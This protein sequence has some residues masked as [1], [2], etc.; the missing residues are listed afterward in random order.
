VRSAAPAGPQAGSAEAVAAPIAGG[1]STAPTRIWGQFPSRVA[2]FCLVELQRLRHDRTELMTRAVQPALWLLIYGETFN[3]LHAIPTGH[4]PYLAFLTPGIVAQ[5]GMFVAIF[6]GIQ[7]IWE[8]DAGVL[9]KL[10]VTPTP[11]SALILGKSFA[12]GIRA[13]AQV[14]VVLVLAAILGVGLTRNPLGILGAFVVVM[15]G[16]AFFSCLSMTVAGVVLKRDRLMGVGQMITMP[17]FFASS[18]LYPISV[19]PRWLQILS[20]ANPLSYEVNALRG[21]L[22]DYPARLGLDFAVLIFSVV[23]GVIAASSLVA[24]LAR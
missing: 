4:V 6:Y 12:A 5:S 21:L 11:R 16:G 13:I 14:I 2:T 15:L 23:V 9:T 24:R 19:M 3:R 20:A 22:I 7:I 17:L 1:T 8:R 18:A 10:L